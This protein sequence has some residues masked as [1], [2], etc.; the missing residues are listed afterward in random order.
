MTFSQLIFSGGAYV[1]ARR[2]ELSA[3]AAVLSLFRYA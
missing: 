2:S 1:Y 3:C